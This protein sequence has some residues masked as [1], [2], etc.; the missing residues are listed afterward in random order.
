MKVFGEHSPTA[1]QAANKL[2][3]YLDMPYELS[4]APLRGPPGSRN[5]ELYKMR[6]LEKLSAEADELLGI[7]EAADRAE[8]RWE[9]EAA[10]S[11]ADAAAAAAA[12]PMVEVAAFPV[13]DPS[14]RVVV[15][16]GVVE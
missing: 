3:E 14:A 9:Q 1:W 15:A 5:P 13:V 12:R 11:A 4:T 16:C 6:R 2:A 8:A 10:A 7:D